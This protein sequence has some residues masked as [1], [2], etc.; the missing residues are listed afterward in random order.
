MGSPSGARGVRG[1]EIVLQR[2]DL[3]GLMRAVLERGKAFRFEARG[4]SMHPIIR[5]GDVVTVR[6]LAGG[7]AKT[8]DVVAFVNPATGGVWIH[9]IVGKDA[10]G[11]R[12]KGDN[13]SCEDGAVPEAALLGWVERV[14][15]EGRPVFL[16]PALRSSLFARLS[17][18]PR[19]CRLVRRLRRTLGRR[20]RRA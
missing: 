19:F 6:P 12:L 1:G 2:D 16:G 7:A 14:E 5:D 15:R 11:Y 9:R 10:A 8:G 4:A 18:S 13:T 17:R 3:A 20:V